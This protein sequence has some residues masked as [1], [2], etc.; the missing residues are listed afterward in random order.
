MV[1]RRALMSCV[2][3]ASLAGATHAWADDQ[4]PSG[5]AKAGSAGQLLGEVVV[6]ARRRE[7]NLQKVPTAVTAFS[8]AALE[9]KGIVNKEALADFTPSMMTIT[10]GYPSEFAYFALR[11]QGPAF[12]S[13]PG[14]VPYFADVANPV[15]IDGR[16][17]TYFDLANVQ[18]LAGPQGTLFGKNAT[19]GNILFQPAKPTDQF[20]GYIRGEYGN[21]NDRRVDGAINLPIVD[22]KVL[23]RVGGEVGRR[24]GYTT[25]VGPDFPGKKYD[26]LD[27]DSARV[28]LTI[29][30]TDRLELY[31]VA[32]YYYSDNNGPGTVLEQLNPATIAAFG[33]YLPGLAN[34]VANQQALGPRK[35][36]YDLDQFSK[37][38]YWQFINHATYKIGDSLSFENIVS[39]SQFRDWYAYDYDASPYPLGGQSNRDF[40]VLAPNY[41]TEEARLQGTALGG[42]LNYTAG[43]YHD[44]QT[45]SGPAGIEDYY[46]IPIDLLVGPVS[47]I[48]TEKN[49]SNAVFGQATFNVGDK[50]TALHGLSVTGGLRYTSER[51]SQSAA[52]AGAPP[53]GGTV[54]SHYPSYTVDIDQSLFGDAAHVYVAVRDAYKSGGINAGLPAGSPFATFAPEQLQDVEVGLKSEFRIGD[55]ATRLNMD[56]YHGDY[57]NIQ[58]TVPQQVGDL[59]LNVNESAAKAVIQGFELTGLVSPMRGLSFTAAYSYTDSEY[60]KVAPVA[61]A[62]LAGAA[63]PYTPRNKVSLGVSYETHVSDRLG[64]FVIS[65]NYTYQSKFST[66]QTNLAEVAYLPGYSY[67]NAEADLK[68]IDGKPVDVALFVDNLTN[69]TY[70]TGLLDFY[71]SSAIGTVTY[72]YAPPRMYGVRIRYQF[73]G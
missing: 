11:G 65:G 33:A 31:T 27:Y 50:I 17:G 1:L 63:F 40:P 6:T 9:Q 3:I 21:F 23:L 56:Y 59:V 49:Q 43:V 45:W 64:T 13:V 7:E 68:T 46:L 41:F 44:Q 58:R 47:D 61:Q 2:A 48:A 30:P 36:S 67:V 12:G 19:G 42:A 70:V 72:T 37:T 54:N 15:G 34:A 35:V 32:R 22:D 39:Y 29:R 4:A 60:T 69:A 14:V 5:Q 73:G 10:G 20:G 38:Q 24:D 16:V 26:N 8:G 62:L 53:A 18:V 28:S 71:N 55:V 25:D 52:I 66:A 51:S 57:S